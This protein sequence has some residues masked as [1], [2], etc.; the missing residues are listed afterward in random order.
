MEIAMGILLGLHLIG[1]ATIL[2]GL[3]AEMRNMKTGAKV[4]AGVVHG[5]WL[6]LLTGL[7][8]VALK[9]MKPEE[10]NNLV[11]SIKGIGI[12]G[13]FFLAYTYQKKENTPK[14]VVPGLLVLVLMN[15]F[16]ATIM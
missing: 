7:I 12:T 16:V 1:F 13:I 4:S 6:A 11:L 10:V 14:W 15:L 3:V 2:G 9:Y 5:A 8:L